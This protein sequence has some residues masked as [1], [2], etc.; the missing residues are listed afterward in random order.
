MA[1]RREMLTVN[2]VAERLRVS[3]YSVR[4]YIKSGRLK[5]VALGK[6]YR[7]FADDL[8]LFLTCLSNRLLKRKPEAPHE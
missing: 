5:A 7:V 4:R 1:K 3:E 2:E 8:D 6:E